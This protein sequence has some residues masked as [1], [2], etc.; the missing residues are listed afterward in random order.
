MSEY[1][2]WNVDKY[3]I[4]HGGYPVFSVDIEGN[5]LQI[6]PHCLEPIPWRILDVARLAGVYSPVIVN[7]T[8][9]SDAQTVAM[10]GVHNLMITI[11]ADVA[12]T[13]TI[14]NSNKTRRYS[15]DEFSGRV[16]NR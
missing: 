6:C 7:M 11:R 5:L 4:R 9:Q 2:G 15:D 14:H 16:D 10:A 3:G 1:D 13:V 12:G 8:L